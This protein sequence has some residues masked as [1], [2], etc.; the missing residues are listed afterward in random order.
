[1]KD[2]DKVRFRPVEERDLDALGRIDTDPAV[3]EP[4]EWRGF[5]DS[6]ARRQRWKEDGYLG[7]EDSLLVVTLPDGTLVGIVVWKWI[8]TSGPRGCL[9]LGIL[10]FPEHRG[11]GLGTAAQRLLADYLF[12]T[13]LANRLEATTEI[14]NVAEQRA[15]ENAGFVREGVLRGRGFVRGQWRDGVMYARLRDDPA[16]QVRI[17]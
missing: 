1:M 3:S 5:R 10:L 17:E 7:S 9:Q 15:L 16:P 11:K 6:A 13:T 8:P 2:D 12:S 4:F 14:D